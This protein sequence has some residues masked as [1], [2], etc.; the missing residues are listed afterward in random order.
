[1]PGAGEAVTIMRS[2]SALLQ[3]TPKAKTSSALGVQSSTTTSSVMA[4]PRPMSAWGPTTITGTL[5]RA[6][7]SPTR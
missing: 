2:L 1:M 7:T 3:A 6:T 4:S 5:A